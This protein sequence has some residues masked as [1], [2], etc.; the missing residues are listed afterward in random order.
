MKA[1]T[2]AHALTN[3]SQLSAKLLPLYETTERLVVYW[4]QLLGNRMYVGV[5]ECIWMNWNEWTE[6]HLYVPVIRPLTFF[7]PFSV[8][9]TVPFCWSFSL[10]F[11]QRLGH[12]FPLKMHKS[13]HTHRHAQT[14]TCIWPSLKLLSLTAVIEG[15]LVYRVW[16]LGSVGDKVK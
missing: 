15:L 2:C 16:P 10:A 4:F 5:N 1:N 8:F 9:K 13:K 6:I 7:P 3:T 11:Q 14:N 12:F